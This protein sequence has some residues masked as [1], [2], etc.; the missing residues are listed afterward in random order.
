MIKKEVEDGTSHS[1]VLTGVEGKSIILNEN[2]KHARNLDELNMNLIT[3]STRAYLQFSINKLQKSRVS[4][5]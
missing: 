1:S 4:S 5:M 2:E 3:K